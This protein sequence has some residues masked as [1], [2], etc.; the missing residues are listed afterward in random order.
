MAGVGEDVDQRGAH[1]LGV[2][3]GGRH[4]RIELELH[5]A[6]V[7]PGPGGG[8]RR[9]AEVVEIRGGEIETNRLGEVEDVGHQV[10]QTR[11]F[12]VD[13]RRC[14]QSIGGTDVVAAQRRQRR[15]DDHQRIPDL[16]SD[17]GRQA[18]Q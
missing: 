6:A 7:V 11:R 18:A 8:R 3:H 12:F 4:L 15:P 5:L 9:A 13:V 16:V 2:G 10:V 14:L 1:A 17:D